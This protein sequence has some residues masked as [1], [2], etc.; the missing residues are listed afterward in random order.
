MNVDHTEDRRMLADMIGRFV[1]E[2]YPCGLVMIDHQ[3][4]DQDHHLA[5]YIALGRAA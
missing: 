3:L 5:R 4:G 2:Q 1:A